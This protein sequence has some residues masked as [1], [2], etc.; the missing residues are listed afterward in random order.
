MYKEEEEEGKKMKEVW[1]AEL[2]EEIATYK[3]ESM[4]LVK[5][6]R[7]REKHKYTKTR[8]DSSQGDCMK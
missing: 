5:W 3:R 2:D 4:Q 6:K 1:R 8:R 7:E